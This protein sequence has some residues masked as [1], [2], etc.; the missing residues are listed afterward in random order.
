MTR[1][2]ADYVIQR[3]G[4]WYFRISVPKAARERFGGRAQ[5]WKSLQTTNKHE[6]YA[7]A[8]RLAKEHQ[9][10][11]NETAAGASE[12]DYDYKT[13]KAFMSER[14][15]VYQPDVNFL[16]FDGRSLVEQLVERLAPLA[17]VANPQKIEVA[18][19]GGVA[20][21]SLNLDEMFKRYQ[22]LSAGKWADL[23]ARQYEKKWNRYREPVDDFKREI[24]DIDVLKITSKD[25]G[26]YVVNLG[27]R[28]EAKRIKSETARKKL[29]FLRAM[30]EKVFK[31]DFDG[32]KNPFHGA[33]IEHSG[34][35]KSRRR[36]L[37]EVEMV[38][39]KGKLATSSTNE[40]LKAILTIME[41]T[42]TSASEIVLLHESDFHLEDEIP[43]VSIRSNPNRAH[44]K[45]DNRPR[46]IPLIGPAL[47]AAMAF[48]RGFPRYC[49]PLGP[50][51]VSALANKII[52]EVT[53]GASTYSLRHRFIDWLREVDG[54][55]DSWLKSIIGHDGSMTGKYGRGYSMRRKLDAIRKAMALAE[56]EQDKIKQKQINDQPHSKEI[57]AGIHIQRAS[58]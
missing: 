34:N 38:A 42:G 15:A 49:R 4:I 51:A 9:R 56:Q 17:I 50:E 24:G 29:L 26:N 47:E 37:T 48:P 25:V 8:G 23:N 1:I 53:T 45:T 55:E 40:E 6:A 20:P 21:V 41:Y 46:D 54:M 16:A 52:R 5:I 32:L 27:K 12:R 30:V 43:Y 28:I 14:G 19:M 35:D 22:E 10:L 18:A 33:E 3:R 31:T 44:L 58:S 57:N 13:L 11:F 39:L 7:A 36:P 2:Y